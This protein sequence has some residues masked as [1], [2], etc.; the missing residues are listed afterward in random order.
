MYNLL[1]LT[2]ASYGSSL[3]CASKRPVPRKRAAVVTRISFQPLIRKLTNGSHATNS[4]VGSVRSLYIL[5]CSARKGFMRKRS[6]RSVDGTG[7][8]SKRFCI[9]RMAHGSKSTP[10]NNAV[11]RAGAPRTG[12]GLAVPCKHCCVCTMTGVKRSFGGTIRTRKGRGNT[13][14]RITGCGATVT[15]GR[16]LGDVSLA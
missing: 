13:T 15:A 12:L 8:A 4:T 1:V 16:K 14:R 3:L 11:T 9:G 7:P 2:I 5:L 6:L 10:S